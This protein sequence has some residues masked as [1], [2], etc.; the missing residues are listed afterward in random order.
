MAFSHNPR[1][2]TGDSLVL[3]IDAAD[4]VS[5]P[6]VGTTWSDLSNNGHTGTL[7]GDPT[8]NSNYGGT[9]EF[10][11]S[12]D[13]ISFPD[14]SD[15]NIGT[16]DF[17]IEQWINV[18]STGSQALFNHWQSSN[19]D[20]RTIHHPSLG[21]LL[22]VNNTVYPSNGQGSVTL[23]AN[24]WHHIVFTRVASTLNYYLDKSV[25]ATQ[26]NFTT[27]IQDYSGAL[28]IGRTE[29]SGMYD[30]EIAITRFYVGKGLSQEEVNQNFNAQRGRF[31]V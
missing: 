28:E 16:A 31:G 19:V 1:I 6:G 2:V 17:A 13:Y 9:I 10:D 20:L 24:A 11:G 3:C 30:G 23:T 26:A 12:G 15:W 7:T 8:F 21:L 4:K 22:Y 5:Y 14:S 29:Q 25:V 18:D 27:N